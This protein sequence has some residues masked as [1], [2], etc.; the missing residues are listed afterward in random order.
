VPREK[1]SEKAN[2]Q[3]KLRRSKRLFSVGK[4][5]KSNE[6][7]AAENNPLGGALLKAES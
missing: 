4:S 7:L 6:K 1:D 5:E 2:P 3:R